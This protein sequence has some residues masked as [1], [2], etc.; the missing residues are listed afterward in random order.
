MG[1]ENCVRGFKVFNP[2]WTCLDKQYT[3]PG[4]FEEDVELDV[5]E[6]GMH[7]CK[8]AVDCF[9][10]YSFDPENKVAEVIAYGEVKEKDDKCC[11]NKLKIIRE[12]PW[13]E[14]LSLVNIGRNCA[15][16]KNTGNLNDGDL[17]SGDNNKGDWNTGN[18]NKGNLNSGFKNEGYQNAGNYNIGNRNS[19][20]CNYGNYNSGDWNMGDYNSGCFNTVSQFL[21]FNKPSKWS[22]DEWLNSDA[23]FI[24]F[25]MPQNEILWINSNDMTDDEK[26]AYPEYKITGGCLREYINKDKRQKWWGNLC[27]EK[28]ELVMSL[29]NFDADIFKEITGIDVTKGNN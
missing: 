18:C 14:L 10:Y 27:S 24:L 13:G 11:T 29:P 19:G 22:Y 23:H 7:F 9:N 5:C 21:M 20:D 4:E 1:E 15:G 12:I 8:R 25:D 16:W 6:S 17:N 3:C 26:A 2:D 28:K